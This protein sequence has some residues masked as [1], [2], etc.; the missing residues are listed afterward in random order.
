MHAVVNM[1]GSAFK[2]IPAVWTIFEKQWMNV[3][4]TTPRAR[5]KVEPGHIHVEGTYRSDCGKKLVLFHRSGNTYF[6]QAPPE[7][8]GTQGLWSGRVHVGESDQNHFIVIAFVSPEIQCLLD[9]YGKVHGETQKWVGI[10]FSPLPP[11]LTVLS[12]V[13]VYTK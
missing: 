11:G 6:P 1:L 9:Y 5:D 4:I 13:Q 2:W 10:R 3:K 8:V 7:L 12:E